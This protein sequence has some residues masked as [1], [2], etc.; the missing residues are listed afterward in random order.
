MRLSPD[1]KQ[2]RI[3]E[4]KA[5]ISSAS[6]NFL[7]FCTISE[8]ATGKACGRPTA[9]AA[10]NGLSAFTCRYHQAHRQRHGSHWCKSPAA[11]TL[12]PYL[13]AALSYIGSHRADPFINAALN[14]LQG[15]MD[16]SG[17][18]E[19]ATRLRGLPPEQRAMI[20]WRD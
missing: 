9:R 8:P 6:V 19:I 14:G 13:A 7:P 3:H 2:R 18:T 15:I 10:K 16:S 17:S 11:S 1:R 4:L 5:R 20:P 12:R